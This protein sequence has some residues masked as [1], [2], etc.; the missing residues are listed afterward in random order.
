MRP[1]DLARG[2]GLSTQAIR[3]Y[4]ADGILPAAERTR[5][6]YRI[7]TPRHVQALRAFLALIPGHGQQA[8]MAIMQ[9]LNAGGTDDAFRLID[10]SHAQLRDDRRTL[11]AVQRAV[12]DLATTTVFEPVAAEPGGLLI[13]PLAGLLGIRPAT[14]RQW[15]RA[16][17]V[18]PRRDRQTGYRVYRESDVR[19]ARLTHQLRRG[20]YL[21]QQIAPVIS[22]LRSAGGPELLEAALSDWRARLAARGRAMLAGAGELEVYLRAR[23]QAPG[24]VVGAA[25]EQEPGQRRGRHL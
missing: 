24:A 16:G 1:V 2:C 7:Y 21:L 22:Q 20:G 6:D 17:L 12:R 19:D 11:D 4:E 8:A 3:N 25:G 9:A 18:E 5:N 15:E 14:L 10:S 23:D 13:G